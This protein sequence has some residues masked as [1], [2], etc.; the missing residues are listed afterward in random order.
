M[1]LGFKA[2]PAA[3]VFVFAAAVLGQAPAD[4]AAA[5]VPP[6][7]ILRPALS[8]VQSTTAELNIS[9]WKLPGDV[10][11]ATEQDVDSIQRDLGSTLPGLMAKADAA[12]ASVPPSFAV[13]RNVDALYDVLL[14]VSQKADLSASS[15][16]AVSIASSL[17][18]LEAARSQ[19]ANSILSTAQRHEAR[20]VALE[21]AVRT[22]NAAPEGRKHENVIVDGPEKKPTKR[23]T[24][25]RTTTH[26][27]PAPKTTDH[28]S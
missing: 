13:Y 11:K 26:K 28:P 8:S 16:E 15:K 21:A 12:P 22:A 23:T 19:L 14:R 9:K 18:S 17:R 20:I 3:L 24:R 7:A 25:H 1:R 2:I 5:V 6:S 10:R 27:K 4:P